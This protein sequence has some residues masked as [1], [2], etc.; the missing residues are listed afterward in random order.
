MAF[1]AIIRHL[2]YALRG[3]RTH[4]AFALLVIITLALGTGTV[5]AVF[6]VFDSVLLRSLPFPAAHEL[7]W[8]GYHDTRSRWPVGPSMPALRQWVAR[9]H[10][11]RQLAAYTGTRKTLTGVP[12]SA[13]VEIGL[14]SSRLFATLGV[15]P[16]MGR[17]FLGSDEATGA[18]PV[19]ILSDSLWRSAFGG[20]PHIVRHFTTIDHHAVQVVGVMGADFTVPGLPADA[21]MP[22]APALGSLLSDPAV[23]L[24]GA[25]GRLRP[26]A[27]IAQAREELRGL[28]NDLATDDL[29]GSGT[30]SSLELRVTSLREFVAGHVRP[31]LLLM[32]G[33]SALVLFVACA[34]VA[35]LCLVRGSAR[36]REIAIQLALGATHPLVV[37]HLLLESLLLST[38][39]TALALLV[40]HWV[41]RIIVRIGASQLPRSAEIG[42][43]TDAFVFAVALAVLTTLLAGLV[44]ALHA[45]REDA[46]TTLKGAATS[47][48]ADRRRVHGREVLV[49]AE[50][51]LTIVLLAGAGVLAKSVVQLLGSGLGFTAEHVLVAS[52]MR[53]I[54][55]WLLDKGPTN[56]FGQSLLE[57]LDAVPGVHASAIAL[58][59]P[60]T[61]SSPV[62]V[63]TTGDAE[64]AGD[65]LVGNADV[66]TGDYFRVLGI[67]LL[68]GRSFDRRDG[69]G[70]R[71]IIIS[72]SVA[73]RLFPHADAI[74][75]H[76]LAAADG[77]NGGPH[78]TFTDY[79]IVGVAG[80]VRAPG[81]ATEPPMFDIYQPFTRFPVPHMTIL[82]RAQA[83]PEVLAPA[84]R[85]I[86]HALDPSQPVTGIRRLDT[87]LAQS[88]TQPRFYLS[89]LGAFAGIALLLAAV[90]LY[91]VMAFTVR[92][93]TREIG[94]RLALGA[95]RGDIVR[96]VLGHGMR[97]ILAGIALGLAGAWAATRLLISL[98][99]GVSPTDPGVFAGVT[100]LMAL[101]AIGAI[102]APVRHALHIDPVVTLRA[103]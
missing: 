103:D 12:G 99:S 101:I 45:A 80:N 52:I 8:V 95:D 63:R 58:E 41:I 7:V 60:A 3:I 9:A 96:L 94:V 93:R 27:T 66:I 50:V 64:H 84:L 49:V 83:R 69:P 35:G 86:V 79:E 72:A 76:L 73:A 33:A 91:G 100:M 88:A 26:G 20:N 28:D 23:H 54:D 1:D 16:V 18:A 98:I 77:N 19:V 43:H 59:P 89:L 6:S 39:A 81:P 75:Q 5:T 10:S 22:M 102:Y 34:N 36:E 82:V 48:S 87:V 44:P 97:L 92:Q 17:G 2:R 29:P 74:G 37:V 61:Q 90:G 70:T 14:V 30:A 11:V 31:M 53:P 46:A 25:I 57:Q 32:L 65:S 85:R 24:A 15:R 78:P 40:A 67:P 56:I 62:L 42:L 4:P 47:H 21:W 13:P 38:A 71:T 68:R 55:P 51:A